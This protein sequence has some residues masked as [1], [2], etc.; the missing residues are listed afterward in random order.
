MSDVDRVVK[1]LGELQ[2]DVLLFGGPYSNLQ[3]SQAMLYIAHK[4]GIAPEN[5]I[6]TGDVI[7]Y[8]ADALAT[9]QL[10]RDECVMVAGNCEQQL[11]VGADDCG[12]GFEDGSACDVLSQGW[13][14]FAD[15]SVSNE[16]R[17]F[18]AAAPDVVV[19]TQSGKRYAVIHGGLS[20]V[21]RF[22]W[23]VSGEA[24]FLQEI[25]LARDAVG[26]VDCIIAGHCGMAFET[27]VDD[28]DWVNVG[29]IGMPPHD[30]RSETRF[31]VLHDGCIGIETLDYD[32]GAARLAMERVGLVQGYEKTLQ[33]GYWPSEDI[34]PASLRR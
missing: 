4:R 30:G 12:C 18:M 7:A 9:L 22:L 34:L 15:R 11:G 25:N 24:E 29:V 26:H 33:T 21:A 3:A 8:C 19:F 5:R 10:W 27:Q 17:L 31:G 20:D 13:Y 1:D 23:P 16:D 2:G 32:F 6:C 28:V 14:P